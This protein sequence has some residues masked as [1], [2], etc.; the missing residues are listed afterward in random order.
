MKSNLAVPTGHL[1]WAL[2]PT[3]SS[4]AA[5]ALS[6]NGPQTVARSSTS[7]AR[8]A[9]KGPGTPRKTRPSSSRFV[10]DE[11]REASRRA[12]RQRRGDL[13]RLAG[14]RAR[15]GDRQRLQIASAIRRIRP[16][17]RI[18][19]RPL[20][21]LQAASGPPKC[22]ISGHRRHS[23]GPRPLFF[24]ELGDPPHRPKT[25]LLFE[26]DQ[27]DHLEEVTD[28]VETKLPCLLKHSSQLRSTMGIA[29]VQSADDH[30]DPEVVDFVRRV[31]DR[32]AENGRETGF[33]AAE[34]FKRIDDL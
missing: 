26:A 23:C 25:L 27:P 30:S 17:S 14:W 28:F 5:G 18:R 32:L 2:I 31:T 10:R 16:G 21:A 4:S 12:R 3:T 22:R 1:L 13:P 8:T 19:P 29:E 9:R 24:P 20:E 7:F 6:Q 33:A 34:A 15:G 11:Q